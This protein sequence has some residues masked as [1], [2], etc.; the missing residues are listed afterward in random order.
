MIKEKTLSNGLKVLYERLPHI[1]S[2]CMGVWVKAGSVNEAKQSR[3]I[4]HFIEHMLFKGTVN[5]TARDI[6][7]SFDDIGGH[8]NAFTGKELTCF[9]AKTLDEHFSLSTDILS[10]MIKNSLYDVK[11]IHREQKVVCEEIAMYNDSPEDY[12]HDRLCE[13]MWR[14]HPLAHP[15]IGSKTTVRALDRES[16]LDYMGMYY[17]PDNM[18]FTVV[19]KF[20]E[21]IML[22]DLEEKFN[23][24]NGK[25]TERKTTV[26]YPSFYC[27][28]N[29]YFKNIEQTYVSMAMEGLGYDSDDRHALVIASNVLGGGMSSKLFQSAREDKGLVY[30][31]GSMVE[32]YK[33][34]GILNIYA[35][36]NRQKLPRL[37]D[38]IKK[39]VD[40]IR[41]KGLTED[42]LKK[43]KDQIKG[44]LVL[45]LENTDARMSSMARGMLLR[46]EIIDMKKLLDKINKVTNEDILR[47]ARNAFNWDR[48]AISVLSIKK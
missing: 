16:L 46:N 48:K 18:L 21:E 5:R 19:G 12:V 9:Y 37:M 29:K 10:D 32:S 26:S 36:T 7:G 33:G 28:S 2:V 3:G 11:M 23:G 14:G 38:C 13:N 40:D 8:L 20:E 43:A 45:G 42:E 15:V 22:A 47:V 44:N 35:G 31:I 24:I 34:G 27:T 6:A 1:R 25:N 17:R 30:S 4:S 39:E 41:E